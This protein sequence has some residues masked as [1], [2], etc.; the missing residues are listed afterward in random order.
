[1]RT[2]RSYIASSVS[3]EFRWARGDYD[4]LPALAAELVNRRVA[5]IAAVGGDLSN[6][7]AKQATANDPNRICDRKRSGSGWT[8]REL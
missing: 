7:A 8:G 4:H 6:K 2:W 5:V 1:V 3:L